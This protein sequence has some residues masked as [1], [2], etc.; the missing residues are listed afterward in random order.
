[1]IHKTLSKYFTEE[2]GLVNQSNLILYQ[3]FIR[4]KCSEKERF[5]WLQF[6][7]KLYD[8]LIVLNYVSVEGVKKLTNFIT[9]SSQQKIVMYM[10]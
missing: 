9:R 6:Y 4:V 3:W 8:V 7:T 5:Y 1:M 10:E 2:E